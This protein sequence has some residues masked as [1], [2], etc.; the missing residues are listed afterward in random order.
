M[1]KFI[2]TDLHN[3]KHYTW[4]GVMNAISELEHNNI[5]K[6]DFGRYVPYSMLKEV[7]EERSWKEE[8]DM[9]TYGGREFDFLVIWKSPTDKLYEVSGSFVLGGLKIQFKDEID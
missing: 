9:D 7:L 1:N 6:Y 8:D 5:N 3:G 4:C 2:E